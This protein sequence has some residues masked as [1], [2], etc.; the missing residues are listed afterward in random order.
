KLFDIASKIAVNSE[1]IADFSDRLTC[2]DSPS[3][4][5]KAINPHLLQT[6]LS[7]L[8]RRPCTLEDIARAT[9]LSTSLASKYTT[10]LLRLKQIIA[11]QKANK[12]FYKTK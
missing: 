12:T 3:D 4:I 11:E 1:V 7:I 9:S 10:E 6:V 8:K 5:Q 2:S